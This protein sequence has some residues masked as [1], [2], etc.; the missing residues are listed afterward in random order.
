MLPPLMSGG[1]M[2][3]AGDQPPALPPPSVRLSQRV[4]ARVDGT[5][6]PRKVGARNVSE[7]TFDGRLHFSAD[8]ETAGE[9]S[10]E[11]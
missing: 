7:M 4:P 11:R 9:S 5:E 8:P 2:P 10:G 1:V 6:R 3:F